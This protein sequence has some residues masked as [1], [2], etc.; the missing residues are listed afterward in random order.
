MNI[1]IYIN[2]NITLKKENRKRDGIKMGEKKYNDMIERFA[3]DF[4]LAKNNDL[5]NPIVKYQKLINAKSE[6][7]M[8]DIELLNELAHNL[9]LGVLEIKY[10]DRFRK[11]KK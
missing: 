8:K 7:M 3:N 6:L 9:R 4:F 1:V 2:R 5:R 10:A 11:E